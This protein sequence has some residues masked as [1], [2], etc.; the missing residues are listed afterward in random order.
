MSSF[1]EVKLAW[2]NG[3]RVQGSDGA[4]WITW[5]NDYRLDLSV[6]TR[7]RVKPKTKTIKQWER[8]YHVNGS[9]FTMLIADKEDSKE[10]D[11]WIGEAYQAKYEVPND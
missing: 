6:W 1:K 9:V 2:A 4:E 7:W 3:E 11:S 5:E 8:K 10:V